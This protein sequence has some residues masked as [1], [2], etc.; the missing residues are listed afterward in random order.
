VTVCKVT[1]VLILHQPSTVWCPSGCDCLQIDSRAGTKIEER[2]VP[3]LK[4]SKLGGEGYSNCSYDSEVLRKG[5]IFVL[6]T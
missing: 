4:N 1:H 5:I 3:Q 6:D 2:E